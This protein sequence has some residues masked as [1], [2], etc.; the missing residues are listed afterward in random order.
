MGIELVKIKKGHKLTKLERV[1]NQMAC[2]VYNYPLGRKRSVGK[3]ICEGSQKLAECY[4]SKIMS[5]TVDMRSLMI[6]IA[7]IEIVNAIFKKAISMSLGWK[8]KD[9]ISLLEDK[10]NGDAWMGL[11]QDMMQIE[12]EHLLYD[13][14]ANYENGEE[15]PI[16]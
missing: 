6:N 8:S 11:R 10:Y 2:D 13:L 5:S 9:A 15:E 12:L 3:E 14:A 7:A 4:M 1:M 16:I